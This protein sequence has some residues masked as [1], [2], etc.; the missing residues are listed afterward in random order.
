M[1]DADVTDIGVAV[2]RSEKTGYYYAVQMFG[3]PKSKVIGFKITNEAGV[4]VE[5]QIEDRK[6]PLPP[7]T[8]RMHEHCRPPKVTFRWPNRDDTTAV[9]PANGEHHVVFEEKKVLRV[10]KN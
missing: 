5:Y 4:E 10:K 7:R 1:L 6:F 8:T 2:A 3:R 9:T